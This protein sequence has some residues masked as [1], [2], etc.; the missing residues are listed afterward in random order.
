L[1]TLLVS[2]IVLA[3]LGGSMAWADGIPTSARFFDGSGTP[4]A[5]AIQSDGRVLAAG[6]IVRSGA[7]DTDFAVMRFNPDGTA[8]ATFGTD[9]RVTTDFSATNDAA[10]AI[11]IQADGRIVV[12]G[13]TTVFLNPGCSTCPT[14]VVALARYTTAGI[15][16]GSFGSGGKVVRAY[17]CCTPSDVGYD[18][19]AVAVAP[20]SDL[21]VAVSFRPGRFQNLSYRL[22]RFSS[23]GTP[24]PD[25]NIASQSLESAHPLAFGSGGTVVTL[26]TNGQLG[27]CER[28]SRL[29]RY[30]SEGAL[31]PTFGG[32]G[33]VDVPESAGGSVAVQPDDKPVVGGWITRLTRTGQL[34]STFGQNGTTVGTGGRV[35]AIGANGSIVDAGTRYQFP[36]SGDFTVTVTTSA[37]AVIQNSTT[38]FGG[39]D[40]A[41]TVAVRPDG[42]ILAAGLSRK[43][44]RTDVAWTELVVTPWRP[45]PP[46]ALTTD[47]DGDR[48]ADM[49]AL[50]RS[51]EWRIATSSSGF[52]ARLS[53]RWGA[54]N[55]MP[56]TADFNGDGRTDLAVYREGPADTRTSA[57]YVID[58]RTLQQ[59]SYAFG[60]PLDLPVPGDYDGDGRTE[61]AF[62]RA[63]W[64]IYNF[65]TNAYNVYSF[66][67]AQDFPVPRDFDG[68]GKTDL[69]IYR[70][71][72]G[73]WQVFNIA[74]GVTSTYQWGLAGD[75]PVPADYFGKGYMA[76]AIYRPSTGDW[77]IYDPGTGE[78]FG[79]R[80]GAPGD[81]P[82]PG[83][84]IGDRRTD[85]ACF[86]PATGAWFVHDLGTGAFLP[87]GLGAPNEPPH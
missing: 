77:W 29:T 18:P 16:D 19:T 87:V 26:G 10:R 32:T 8:D 60:G 85:L 80:W 63:G 14:K 61:L 64:Y 66:G 4:V 21:F 57:W 15:L 48:K 31:D 30:T 7:G 55:D 23:D 27:C 84:Y 9:G 3:T 33:M 58:P 36:S 45:L 5:V 20:N 40:F 69:A 56:V 59:A 13:F 12:A 62:Y 42:S 46:A 65:A 11:A 47:F 43:A 35:V 50:S 72:T 52:A 34:D 76:I 6:S 39:D 24:L 83:D 2:P 28:R 17:T 25:W 22:Y 68:D 38:D 49:V 86:R 1:S 53:Y 73:V 51:G 54:A 75:I 44:D 74:T 41:D 81:V 37:G 71:S 70:P 67:T 78:Y 79:F 82:V